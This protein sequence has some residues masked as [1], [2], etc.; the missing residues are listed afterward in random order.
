VAIPHAL[1]DAISSP[2]A[3]FTRLARPIDFGSADDDPVDLLFTLFW[4]RRGRA[5]FL[6]ALALTCRLLRPASIRARLRN[7]RSADEVM[8]ILGAE[9]EPTVRTPLQRP[10]VSAMEWRHG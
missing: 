3:S 8:A 2:I 7:A 9:A 4:P 6:P 5:L 10:P 1:L